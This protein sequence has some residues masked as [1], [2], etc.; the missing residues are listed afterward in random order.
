MSE[1]VDHI[2]HRI[3]AGRLAPEEARRGEC[4]LGEDRPAL[5]TV[6]EDEAFA[7]PEKHY[8]MIARDGTAT[9]R[10][11]ADRSRLTLEPSAVARAILGCLAAAS[12]LGG[13]A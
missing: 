13:V 10:R 2:A 12:A 7:F 11:I 8:V 9:D 3:E 4:P 6:G 1:R 5:G